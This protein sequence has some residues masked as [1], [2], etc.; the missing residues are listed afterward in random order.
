ME[1]RVGIIMAN[2]NYGHYFLDGIESIK[3]QT[4]EGPI[5][6]YVVDDG[7]TDDSWEKICNITEEDSSEQIE[8][9]YYTGPI[10]CR[11]GENL[12]AYRIKNSGA[13]TARNVGINKAFSN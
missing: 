8:E 10:E 7:S 13:S 12:F 11:K 2:Y 9:E 1:T 5:T 3:N 4:Y 6:T